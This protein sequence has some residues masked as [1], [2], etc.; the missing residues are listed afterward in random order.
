MC[1]DV[2]SCCQK[3]S[4]TKQS[5]IGSLHLGCQVLGSLEVVNMQVRVW[6]SQPQIIPLAHP[7]QD[8][9]HHSLTKR[10]VFSFFF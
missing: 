2:K 10:R 4:T 3:K 9:W 1:A 6:R 8:Y 5:I 7:T